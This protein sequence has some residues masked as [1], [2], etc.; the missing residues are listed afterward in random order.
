MKLQLAGRVL[1]EQ[2]LESTYTQEELKD[3]W[4]PVQ[5]VAG[6]TEKQASRADETQ[7]A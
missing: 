3:L 6:L 2:T 4:R 5:L 7:T 1:D